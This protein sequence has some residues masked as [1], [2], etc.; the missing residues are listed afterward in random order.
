MTALVSSLVILLASGALGATLPAV[1]GVEGTANPSGVV[2]VGAANPKVTSTAAVHAININSPPQYLTI[3]VVNKHGDAIST[4]HV[5]DPN[6]P[7]AVS[8]NVGPGTMANGATAAFA[9]P[10]GWIGNVA[11]NDAA[12]A[13]TG[14]DTLIE[15]NFI[16]P[17][18][19]SV[20]V[21]DVDVSYVNGFSVAI[22]CSCSGAVVAGCNKNLYNLN[23][24]GHSDGQNACINPLRADSSATSAASFFTPCQHAAW[25][26]VNDDA[27]NSF[28]QCQ[29]GEITCCVG[30][31]CTANPKQPA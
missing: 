21:A 4:S 3:T 16:I 24:C 25:T 10:T 27:A 30:A 29:S 6:A 9:V 26:Y 7:A 23:T 15:A 2:L 5:H 14:D 22:T 8:G 19:Y 12:W 1:T 28:G 31:A 11:I 18:G 13:L 20:A 17:S